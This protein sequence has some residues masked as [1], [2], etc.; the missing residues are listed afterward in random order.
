MRARIFI[1]AAVIFVSGQAAAAPP[2]TLNCVGFA[3]IDAKGNIELNLFSPDDTHGGAMLLIDRA[4]PLY[5]DI[6]K[7]VGRLRTGKWKCVNPW[8]RGTGFENSAPAN[9]LAPPAQAG[10]PF[11]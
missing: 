11:K 8:G 2:S 6:R 9:G 5:S 4:H 1:I 10:V 7:H 3:S